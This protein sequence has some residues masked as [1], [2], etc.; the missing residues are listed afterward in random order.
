MAVL[1]VGCGTRTAPPTA[2]ADQAPA[3]DAGHVTLHVKDMA[4]LLKLG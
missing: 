2:E 4:K 3:A 1:V